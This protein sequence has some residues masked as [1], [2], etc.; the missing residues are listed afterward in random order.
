VVVCGVLARQLAICHLQDPSRLRPAL[1]T[2]SDARRLVLHTQLLLVSQ[3]STS[4]PPLT[5]RAAR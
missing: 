3:A 5:M 1:H 2:R 4:A